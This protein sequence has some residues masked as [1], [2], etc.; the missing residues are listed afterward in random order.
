MGKAGDINLNQ[1]HL[2]HFTAA[3]KPTQ[4]VEKEAIAVDL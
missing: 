1:C 3:D 2:L 4:L